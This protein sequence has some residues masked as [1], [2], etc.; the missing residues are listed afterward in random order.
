MEWIWMYGPKGSARSLTARVQPGS[1]PWNWVSARG[2]YP[3]AC[4]QEI[5]FAIASEKR[6]LHCRVGI[7]TKKTYSASSPPFCC[8][9][10][11]RHSS[12]V[13]RSPPP[14]SVSHPSGISQSSLG[15]C[16]YSTRKRKA[17]WLIPKA[18]RLFVVA[19]T[20]SAEL[21]R[22]GMGPSVSQQPVITQSSPSHQCPLRFLSAIRQSS[23]LPRPPSLRQ[24]SAISLPPPAPDGARSDPRRFTAIICVSIPTPHPRIPVA[25][26]PPGDMPTKC[27]FSKVQMPKTLNPH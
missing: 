7:A 12:A 20:E 5:V 3:P 27:M 8:P 15:T 17:S 21:N 24:Q 16:I 19:G 18:G 13:V 23:G 11:V 6:T 1:S 10:F 14:S 9:P 4:N 2:A 25:K 26:H 22:P